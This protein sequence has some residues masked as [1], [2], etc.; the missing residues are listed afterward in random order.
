ML[1]SEA[2]PTRCEGQLSRFVTQPPLPALLRKAGCSPLH[3]Q[4]PSIL[5]AF[6]LV[7]RQAELTSHIARILTPCPEKKAS[8]RPSPDPPPQPA[9]SAS[10][11]GPHS[12]RHR[13]LSLWQPHGLPEGESVPS[14]TQK[15]VLWSFGCLFL[16]CVTVYN[17]RSK[18]LLFYL[19]QACCHVPCFL[20]IKLL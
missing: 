6:L 18:F 13:A 9:T 5:S 14:G 3:T 7:H 12:E 20:A 2:L 16:R 11:P 4:M 17:N 19:Y 8:A 15:A 1:F 10:P